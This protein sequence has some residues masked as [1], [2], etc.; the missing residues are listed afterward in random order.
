MAKVVALFGMF[1]VFLVALGR[2]GVVAFH[3]DGEATE[4]SDGLLFHDA[5]RFVILGDAILLLADGDGIARPCNHFL[6]KK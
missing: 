4:T 6:I 2:V 5:G 3:G 1:G